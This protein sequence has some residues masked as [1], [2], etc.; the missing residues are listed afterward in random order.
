MPNDD[1]QK[2][3]L[4][5]LRER[6]AS[7]TETS[8]LTPEGKDATLIGA[9]GAACIVRGTALIS[10]KS[11]LGALLERAKFAR[12]HKAEKQAVILLAHLLAKRWVKHARLRHSHNLTQAIAAIVV[13]EWVRD[14][15]P[16]C[17]GAGHVAAGEVGQRNTLTK[18]CGVCHGEGKPKINHGARASLLGVRMEAYTAHWLKR[19][20]DAAGWVRE[21][22]ADIVER[23]RL[24]NGRGTIRTVDIQEVINRQS[25]E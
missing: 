21:L 25:A 19:V 12:D 9:L 24:Q 14:R 11:R 22:E 15:C 18:V 4:P 23:L 16:Q 1:H 8:D 6:L 17:G 10:G 7:A 2:P 5:D 20:E 13:V 3:D